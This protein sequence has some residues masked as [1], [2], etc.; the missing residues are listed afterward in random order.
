M[1]FAFE[2]HFLTV[3]CINF[4]QILYCTVVAEESEYEL[5]WGNNHGKKRF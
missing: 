3:L 2:W 4:I 5:F 1:R